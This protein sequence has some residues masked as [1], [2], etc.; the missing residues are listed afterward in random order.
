MNRRTFAAFAGGA[1]LA[2]TA[3]K[4]A[5]ITFAGKEGGV[6]VLADGQPLT[7]FH[8]AAKWDKPFLHPIRTAAGKVISRGYPFDPQP[9]DSRDHEWHRGVWWGH[10]DINKH[11]FWR[12]Q[13][14]QK[15][16]L[17]VVAG[18]PKL[19]PVAAMLEAQMEM[20]IP[21][22]E[23]IG[24]VEQLYAFQKLEREVWITATITVAADKG[25]SLTFGDTDD[26]GFAFRL[27]ESFRQDKGARLINSDG[28]ETTEKIWGKPARWIDYS[29]RIDGEE[30]GVAMF[31]HSGN[32]RHPT[33]WH[34][35][36]YSLAAANPFALGSFAKDKSQRGAY[37][38]EAGQRMKLRYAIVIHT[39]PVT[40][41]SIE[42]MYRRYTASRRLQ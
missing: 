32:L 9:G 36:G 28:L 13:G 6:D 33:G 10:G 37:T 11:D 38:L 39:G 35:R 5:R 1:M 23:V 17:L 25:Q 2:R 42:A 31:D 3:M 24:H 34:A 30:T 12:E 14:R 21:S 41:D 40:A 16:S 4:P 26:G 15:T 8:Y 20:R 27:N 22:G 7:T 18:K 19:R 29:A